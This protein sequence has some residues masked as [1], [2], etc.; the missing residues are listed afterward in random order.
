VAQ[1]F[2]ASFF[3]VIKKMTNL[4]KANLE[5]AN[6]NGADLTGVLLEGAVMP[7]GSIKE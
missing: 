1:I 6:I 3:V 5:G 4:R 7:D 2:T